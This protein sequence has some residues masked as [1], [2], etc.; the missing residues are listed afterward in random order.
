MTTG[1]ARE[2][3]QALKKSS[4][5]VVS[6]DQ[7]D[8]AHVRS[9]ANYWLAL[10]DG[11]KLPARSQL[12]PR[13]LAAFLRN[14]VLLRVIDGGA[15]FEYRITGDAHVQAFGSDFHKLRTSDIERVS[16]AHGAQMR[17]VYEHV[18]SSAAPFAVRGWVGRDVKDA[19]FIYH[20]SVFLPL[21][22]D[23]VTV[24]HI[25]VVTMYVPKTPG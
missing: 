18:R 22:E 12:L 7:I 2:P 1:I 21:A 23:R 20:E 11:V 6:L 24:D 8:N 19:L 3:Q 9:A 14:I 4:V 13:E 15:D 25:L 17:A 16:P 5:Q 10:R